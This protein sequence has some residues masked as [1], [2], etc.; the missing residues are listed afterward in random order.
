[1]LQVKQ[2]FFNILTHKNYELNLRKFFPLITKD[3]WFDA[4]IFKYFSDWLNE[5]NVFSFSKILLRP[6]VKY[7][8]QPNLD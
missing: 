4:Q 2:G 5:L 3:D 7:C 8:D 6:S 1:M